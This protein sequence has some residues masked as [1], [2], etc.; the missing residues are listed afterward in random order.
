[1]IRSP[2][3]CC[4]VAVLT[5]FSVKP[6]LAG[7]PVGTGKLDDRWSIH[8]HTSTEAVAPLTR[9][10]SHELVL[11]DG[12]VE[13]DVGL[14]VGTARQFLWFNSFDAP[15]EIDFAVDEIQVLF[16]AGPEIVPGAAV[17]LVVF[18]DP[19]G[20]PTNGAD[21]LGS[22]D[23]QVQVADGATFSIYTVDPPLAVPSGSGRVLVGVVNRFVESGVSPPSRPAAL[24][25]DSSA[26]RSWIATWVGDPP[27]PLA[28]PPDDLLFTVDAL[29]PGNWMIRALGTSAT[30][31]EVPVLGA[32]GAAVLALL[33]AL[34]AAF[35][36]RRRSEKP[37]PAGVR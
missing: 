2:T 14:S 37:G 1:M 35:G 17:E 19:D 22:F 16:P 13:A 11:D 31:V 21:L 5:L 29:E 18:H 12:S 6:V 15:N 8:R 4:L 24:D 28:L 30:V 26:G 36:L 23:D 27:S 25:T 34:V 10:V 9:G 3:P 33:L 20:D 7:D 32:S